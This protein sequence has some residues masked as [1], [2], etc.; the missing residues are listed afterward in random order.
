[1]YDIIIFYKLTFILWTIVEYL[2]SQNVM[3]VC[4]LVEFS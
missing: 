4:N 3:K 1:M 2:F